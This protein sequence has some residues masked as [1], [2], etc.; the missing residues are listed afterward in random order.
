MWNGFHITEKT[1]NIYFFQ[2]V[3]RVSYP[4]INEEE[5]QKL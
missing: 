4:K 5:E 3:E 1:R 2:N